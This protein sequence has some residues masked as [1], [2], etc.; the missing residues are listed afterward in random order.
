MQD[1][2]TIYTA[3]NAMDA[4]DETFGELVVSRAL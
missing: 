4:L 3:N 1:N 2:A